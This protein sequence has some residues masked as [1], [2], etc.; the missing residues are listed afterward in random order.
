M[1]LQK[2]TMFDDEE[3]LRFYEHTYSRSILCVQ[4]LNKNLWGLT[5]QAYKHLPP[6]LVGKSL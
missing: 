5:S 4:K 2:E 1:I 3:I 6:R